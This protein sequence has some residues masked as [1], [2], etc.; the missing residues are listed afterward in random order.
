[1]IGYIISGLANFIYRLTSGFVTLNNLGRYGNYRKK[2][3]IHESFRFNGTDILMYGDGEI[4]AGE[5]SYIGSYSSI[6]AAPG[7]SVSIGRGCQISHFVSVYTSNNAADKDY[8]CD[9]EMRSG[10]VSIGDHCW[11]GI[12]ATVV[13]PV[14]IGENSCVA[15]NSLVSRDI[16][17]HSIAIGVPAKVIKFKSYLTKERM[18]ELATVYRGVLSDELAQRLGL[19]S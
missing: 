13:G 7:C 6:Q 18:L 8:S 15:A 16:P 10:N 14:T 4:S 1:M 12:K 17:P 11:I 2:Y 9:N 5:N 19:V 3:A